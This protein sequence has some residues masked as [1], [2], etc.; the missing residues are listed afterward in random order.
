MRLSIIFGFFG[1]LCAALL[2]G[3]MAELPSDAK[4]HSTYKTHSG[5]QHTVSHHR[6]VKRHSRKRGSS[7]GHHSNSHHHTAHHRASAHRRHISHRVNRNHRSVCQASSSSQKY[8]SKRAAYYAHK[9]GIPQKM[10]VAQI[11]QESGFRPCAIGPAGTIGIAQIHPRTAKT[12]KVN[13]HNPEASLNASARHMADYIHHYRKKG[14]SQKR[15]ELLALH[16]YGT[17]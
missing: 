13:P 6:T 5:K 2:V 3:V 7:D 9:H 8:W 15:A 1:F 16:H 17:R 14:V 12:W 11:R 10:F 4:I